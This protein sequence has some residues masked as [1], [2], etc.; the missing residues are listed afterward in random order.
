MEL[1]AFF[2]YI[3]DILYVSHTHFGV[4]WQD[5]ITMFDARGCPFRVLS[6]AAGAWLL[7]W[8]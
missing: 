6:S 2:D 4:V 5:K 1:P 8:L 3:A 7:R